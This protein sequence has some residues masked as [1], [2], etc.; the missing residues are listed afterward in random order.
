MKILF[1]LRNQLDLDYIYQTVMSSPGELRPGAEW[2]DASRA[3]YTQR[4]G[5]QTYP[6]AQWRFYYAK[7]FN[8]GDQPFRIPGIDSYHWWMVRLDPGCVF[9]LHKDTFESESSR[10]LWIPLTAPQPGH[11]FQLDGNNIDDFVIGNVYEFSDKDLEHGSANFG[12]TPKITL[13]IV[14]YE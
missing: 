11:V 2:A 1:N 12:H 13:Q 8:M 4:A 3:Q 5:Q 14:T 9:P 10:R 6:G 7:D